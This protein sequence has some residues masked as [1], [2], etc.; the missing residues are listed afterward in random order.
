MCSDVP[1]LDVVES[2]TMEREESV[3]RVGAA[4]GSDGEFALR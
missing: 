1:P 2:L 3:E 4:L